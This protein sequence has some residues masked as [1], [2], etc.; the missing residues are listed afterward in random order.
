MTFISSRRTSCS[1]CKLTCSVAEFLNNKVSHGNVVTHLRC[2]DIFS[3][4]FNNHTAE[5]AAWWKNFENRS[6]FGG[7]MVKNTVLFV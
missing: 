3:D 7:V 1:R 2:S 6:T 5:S 4:Q